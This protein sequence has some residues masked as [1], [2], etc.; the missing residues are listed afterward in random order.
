MIKGKYTYYVLGLILVVALFLKVI[1]F[2][3][4]DTKKIKEDINKVETFTLEGLNNKAGE[5]N[6]NAAPSIQATSS[7]A[8]ISRPTQNVPEIVVSSPQPGEIISS[9]LVVSGQ[10]K[11]SWFFEASLPIKLLDDK[12]EV[13]ATV[14]AQAEGDWMTDSLVPFKT[15]LNFQTTASSGYLLISKDNP[16]GLPEHDASVRISVKFLNK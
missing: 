7:V 8:D 12:G 14:P 10:A 1:S 4:S 2:F 5:A 6:K 15:L 9:P 11:G 3:S 16:S 13:I